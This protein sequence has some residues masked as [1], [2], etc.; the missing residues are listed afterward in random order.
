MPNGHWW[1]FVAKWK[2]GITIYDWF[3][4]AAGL[5]WWRFFCLVLFV[6]L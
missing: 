5:G 2:L 6:A 4:N 1:Q 3:K